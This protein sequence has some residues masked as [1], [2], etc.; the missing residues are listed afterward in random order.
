[1][2]PWRSP[3]V[4]LPSGV[5]DISMSLGFI[6][7]LLMKYLIPQQTSRYPRSLVVL[8]FH[9]PH[10]SAEAFTLHLLQVSS[11]A[12]PLIQVCKLP[13]AFLFLFSCS[14]SHSFS[15]CIRFCNIVGSRKGCGT[16]RELN[17]TT[18]NTPSVINQT[19]T[20]GMLPKTSQGG[21][22]QRQMYLEQLSPSQSQPS[23]HSSKLE[24]ANM[25]A[26]LAAT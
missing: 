1:M 11:Y 20:P 12:K 8:S 3:L 13:S 21:L 18:M 14:I 9:S 25:R 16:A 5:L 19:L 4:D 24:V 7:P 22:V 15:A 23:L 6:L 10:L 26:F 2:E 17:S